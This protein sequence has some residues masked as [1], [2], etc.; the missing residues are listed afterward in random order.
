MPP[1]LPTDHVLKYPMGVEGD[2][3]EPVETPT[4]AQWLELK[5]P[6]ATNKV[7]GSIPQ[8][9]LPSGM[10]TELPVLHLLPASP[11]GTHNDTLC[12]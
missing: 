8:L 6:G 7:G 2:A 12:D 9:P 1:T 10:T 11:S 4:I 3:A 5:S